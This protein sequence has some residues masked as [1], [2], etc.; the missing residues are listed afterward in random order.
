MLVLLFYGYFSAYHHSISR[1]KGRTNLFRSATTRFIRCGDAFDWHQLVLTWT[2]YVPNG[3][4]SQSWNGFLE[5]QQIHDSN[6]RIHDSNPFVRIFFYS[7]RW[8]VH[9]LCLCI[10][11]LDAEHNACALNWHD[12]SATMACFANRDCNDAVIQSMEPCRRFTATKWWLFL[13]FLKKHMIKLT[14]RNWLGMASRI[15]LVYIGTYN[16][17]FCVKSTCL[18]TLTYISTPATRSQLK[19]CLFFH[20]WLF[21]CYDCCDDYSGEVRCL[22]FAKTHEKPTVC[23]RWT[24]I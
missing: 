3:A 24:S 5:R 21:N 20:P 19:R 9:C 23:L 7:F 22:G 12:E 14:Q 17:I 2:I 6:E 10:Q 1:L 13:F 16:I 4:T 8:L 11:R 15:V 18:I